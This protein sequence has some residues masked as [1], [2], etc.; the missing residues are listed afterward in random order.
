MAT[1]NPGIS[2]AD[3]DDLRRRYDP[4]LVEALLTMADLAVKQGGKVLRLFG[5]LIGKVRGGG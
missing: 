3:L 1:L 2:D 5:E 4:G